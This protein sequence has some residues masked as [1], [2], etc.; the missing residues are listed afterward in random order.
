MRLRRLALVIALPIGAA[1]AV[2][3][4]ALSNP[5]EVIRPLLVS[6]LEQ[7]TGAEVR[8]GELALEGLSLKAKDVKIE[9]QGMLSLAAP[10]ALLR[11]SFGASLR[12]DFE[13]QLE[14][15]V[16][17]FSHESL[18]NS[19]GG[20]AG[21]SG[22]MRIGA[23]GGDLTYAVAGRTLRVRE[24]DGDLELGRRFALDLSGRFESPLGGEWPLR[25]RI[26]DFAGGT[27]IILAG[28]NVE[29]P[30]LKIESL[31]AEMKLHP[32]PGDGALT[33]EKLSVAGLRAN[34]PEEQLAAQGVSLQLSGQI[35][36]SDGW[37]L[38]AAATLAAEAALAGSRF[39]D[40]QS[41][42][43]ALTLSARYSGG[44]FTIRSLRAES[45]GLLRL[46]ASARIE[47][48]SS[49]ARVS[50]RILDL[51]RFLKFVAPE[52]EISG[53]KGPAV[54]E[55]EIVSERGD[56][57]ARG[58][59]LIPAA[60]IG[61][62]RAAR[63][64]VESAD[65]PFGF[66]ARSRG[67][68]G[69]GRIVLG[70][71]SLQGFTLAPV[72]LPV[73]AS[74][75]RWELG[76]SLRLEKEGGSASLAGVSLDL[77]A[78]SIR[79]DGALAIEE[80]PLAPL[81]PGKV[82]GEIGRISLTP[83]ALELHAG[84]L[85]WLAGEVG[86]PSLIVEEPFSALPITRFEASVTGVSL[87]ELTDG[88]SFGEI[89]GALDG[90]LTGAVLSGSSPMG[91]HASFATRDEGRR[92]ISVAAINNLSVISQGAIMSALSQ[93]IYQFIDFYRYS[94]I[95]I[96]ARLAEDKF[97]VR[98]AAKSGSDRYLVYGGIIPPKIDILAPEGSISFA[99][100]MKRLRRID[101]VGETAPQIE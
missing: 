11:I 31:R 42:P 13:L 86:L 68:S 33:I 24:V 32:E 82:T 14:K 12:P 97:Q 69:Q 101:R 22:G 52:V 83:H 59:A 21:Y 51:G 1:L 47:A 30:A 7:G 48:Q 84:R 4:Y 17:V 88:F 29:S 15:P 63:L 66:G 44:A 10:S 40:L 92:N 20:G 90:Q 79:L 98:G 43:L 96:E 76:S 50:A 28:K 23:K 87:K 38:D 80:L 3:G 67:T 8:I 71:S 55:T 62:A 100:L 39:F 16:V 70:E 46:D 49:S 57:G 85:D 19:G 18:A 65:I 64:R 53:A 35:S 91:F 36:L 37:A 94:K 6:R 72:E 5:D 26:E 78:N 99:E 41:L 27:S 54:L 61:Y 2:L 89:N 77:S 9:R 56:L 25:L 81:L 74:E 93:G 60:E 34:L 58:R 45:K 75:N 73:R 95:G